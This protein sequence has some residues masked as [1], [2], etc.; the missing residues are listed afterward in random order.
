VCAHLRPDRHDIGG[1]EHVDCHRP[2]GGEQGEVTLEAMVLKVDVA[3]SVTP[4]GVLFAA[5]RSTR[6]DPLPENVAC[7]GDVHAPHVEV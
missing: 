4:A 7:F 1:N 3:Q 6:L 5:S 2:P